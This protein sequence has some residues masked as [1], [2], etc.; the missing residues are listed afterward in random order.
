[1]EVIKKR[2]G[3]KSKRRDCGEREKK[4]ENIRALACINW[5]PCYKKGTRI[6][7][8]LYLAYLKKLSICQAAW[9]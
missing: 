9:R 5:K 6:F 7:T 3:K 4:L 2:A 8:L 1:M